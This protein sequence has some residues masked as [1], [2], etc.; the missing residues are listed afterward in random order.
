ME[1]NNIKREGKKNREKTK[2]KYEINQN[3]STF[4]IVASHTRIKNKIC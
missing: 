4:R 3:S 1:K 2:P